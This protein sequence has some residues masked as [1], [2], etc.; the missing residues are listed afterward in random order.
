MVHGADSEV[1]VAPWADSEVG[2]APGVYSEVEAV[3]F[4]LG[5]SDAVPPRNS[6]VFTASWKLLFAM[7]MSST[8]RRGSIDY[9]PYRRLVK[10]PK[11]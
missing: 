1:D 3:P 4:A 7:R 11:A 10:L 6:E 9:V 8:K 2:A 5:G